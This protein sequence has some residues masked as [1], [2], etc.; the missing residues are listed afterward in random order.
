MSGEGRGT[1][2]FRLRPKLL[3]TNQ[4]I[5]FFSN[6]VLVCNKWLSEIDL[7]HSMAVFLKGTR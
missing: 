4:G 7:P 6:I 1:P 3:V 5:T 2:F